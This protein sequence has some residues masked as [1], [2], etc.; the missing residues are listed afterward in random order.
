[1]SSLSSLPGGAARRLASA[2]LRRRGED[3]GRVH[4]PA[5]ALDLIAT[6]L[7]RAEE[8]L[9]GLIADDV[10]ALSHIGAYLL[11]SGGKRL[12]PALTALGARAAG[13]PEGH[14]LL[15]CC[16]ELIHL[17]S[18]LH[19]DVVDEGSQRRGRAS[20]NV[21]FGNAAAVLSG[22]YCVARALETAMLEGG[23]G[24]GVSLA[25]T[26]A[27]MAAGEV[28]QL[29]L[30]GRLDADEARYFAVVDRKSA[31]LIAWCAS[32]GA[33]AAEQEQAARALSAYGRQVGIAFQIAD[34]VL[35]YSQGT[36][37]RA[38]ADLRERKIT[39]PLLHAMRRSPELK[40][41]LEVGAPAEGELPD[42]IALVIESGGLQSA[43]EAA[44]AFA[45]RG[46]E[47]LVGLPSNPARDALAA[48]AKWAVE[49]PA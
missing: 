36:G 24:A 35:D 27:E 7:A 41:R 45:M 48:V 30:A 21:A 34:D 20:A 47:A 1:M 22:D 28:A 10:S 31:A 16:G 44:H 9:R 12:R 46:R 29:Q 33:L 3:A 15:M 14:P 17:G 13:L 2:G 11:A 19:D 43:L 49:R 4:G 42:L 8:A 25:Q 38:G 23:V 37:K 40:Q 6:D 18:L 39:L 26:V 5:A 32:A